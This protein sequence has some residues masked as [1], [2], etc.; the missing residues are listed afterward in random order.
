MANILV[1]GVAGFIGSAVAKRLLDMGHT[2]VGID[3]LSTGFKGNIA[4]KLEFIKGHCHE[5]STYASIEGRSFDAIIHL[6]G[7]N[8]SSVGFK[9]PLYDLQAN[10]VST[11]QLLEFARRNNCNRFL[12]ASSVSVYGTKNDLAVTETEMCQPES[13]YGAHKLASENYLHIYRQYG[14]VSTALRLFNVY[15]PGQNM[16]APTHGIISIFMEMLENEGHIIIKGSPNRIRDF[17]YIDDAVDAF[18]LCLDHPEAENRVFNIARG[19]QHKVGE[20]ISLLRNVSKKAVTLEYFG[21]TAGDVRSVYADISLAVELLG[22][23][24]QVSLSEGVRRMYNWYK[25]IKA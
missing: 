19:N 18:V 2:V 9:D 10:T 11:Y 13:F 22:F 1:T 5:A 4:K 23:E 8:G 6:A 12:L 20:L 24:P 16:V 3:N 17:I 15:G 25:E 14:I 21:S 7:Q